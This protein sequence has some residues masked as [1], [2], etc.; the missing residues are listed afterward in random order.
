MSYV[1]LP[2]LKTH[3]RLNGSAEDDALQLFLDTAESTFSNLTLR[4]LDGDVD[5]GFPDGVPASVKLAILLLAAHFYRVRSAF[6]DQ[7]VAA[8][9][10]G[11]VSLCRQYAKKYVSPGVL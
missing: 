11:F 3:L 8:M 5:T 1:T 2:E 9:P 7:D 10:F 6:T 4:T